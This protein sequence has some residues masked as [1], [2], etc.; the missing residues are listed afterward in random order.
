MAPAFFIYQQLFKYILD[1]FTFAKLKLN[2]YMRLHKNMKMADLVHKNYLLVPVMNRFGI[3]L[4]F[5]DKSVKEVCKEHDIDSGFFMEIINSFHEPKYYPQFDLETFPLP[6]AIRYLS[7]T[8]KSYLEQRLP[9]IEATIG[10]ILE[11]CQI[12]KENI[13]LLRNFFL[14]YKSELSTHIDREENVVYPYVTKVF[15]NYKSEV[16]DIEFIQNMISYSIVDYS[17]EHDNVEEKLYDLKNIII[18]YLPPLKRQV[19][20]NKILFELFRLETD[21]NDHTML[22]EKVMI[23]M[24]LL[25]EEKLK[26]RAKMDS[27]G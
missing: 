15:E 7:N 11:T 27:K 6:L 1:Y 5:G 10:E 24:V 25:M 21:L 20:L 3:H 19:L 2:M 17:N 23:P 9:E 12:N 26:I 8:H 16:I 14:E 13:L 18:K 22:E 4:G